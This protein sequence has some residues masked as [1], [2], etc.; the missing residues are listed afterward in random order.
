MLKDFFANIGMILA[1]WA[2]TAIWLGG[3]WWLM[4]LTYPM[5]AW[6]RD[7][8]GAMYALVSLATCMTAM[9]R[10]RKRLAAHP[11]PSK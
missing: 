11:E 5:G 6:V 7:T 10:K 2:G 1:I 4:S 9:E 3:G 8:A